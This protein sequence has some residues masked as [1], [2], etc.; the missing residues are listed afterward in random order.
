M[1]PY[2]RDASFTMECIN[3]HKPMQPNDQTFTIP[4]ADTLAVNS[5]GSSDTL[6]PMT[7]KVITTVVH[8][9]DGSMSTLYGNDVAV[10]DARAG[11]PYSAGAVVTLVTW[12]Q[13]DDPHWFGGRIPAAVRS[14]EVLRYDGGEP[15]YQSYRGSGLAKE[16][17]IS[18]IAGLKAAVLP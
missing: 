5:L 7:G 6:R 15:S 2:G 4:L 12:E 16:A 14:V 18:Y 9:R 3:C 8:Q 10:K 11:K 13:R 17:R 1:K